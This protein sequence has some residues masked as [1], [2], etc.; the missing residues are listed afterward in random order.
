MEY[1][2]TSFSHEVGFRVFTFLG[3][4]KDRSRHMFT[5]RAELAL[6]RRHG[7]RVQDLPLLCR[8]LLDH[9]DLNQIN[10]TFTYTEADM[11]RHADFCTNRDAEAAAKRKAPRRITRTP[12]PNLN[13]SW[14]GMPA[15]ESTS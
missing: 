12:N 3:T 10:S 14:R 7:I 8:A 5:V 1:T 15:R 2:L 4:D 13:S 9:R 11:R 6:I